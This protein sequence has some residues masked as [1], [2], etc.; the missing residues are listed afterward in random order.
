[1]ILLAPDTERTVLANLAALL[2]PRR[3]APGR[4]PPARRA[5]AR[6]R[7][8]TPSTSSS[9]TA[10]RSVSRSSTRFAV[11]DLRPFAED[12]DYVVHV[13]RRL[14]RRWLAIVNRRRLACPP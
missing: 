1:M 9:P 4:L 11:Y 6:R 12:S 2:A 3:P 8:S 10:P 5:G 7:A 14:A 13:L